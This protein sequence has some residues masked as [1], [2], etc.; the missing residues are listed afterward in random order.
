[1]ILKLAAHVRGDY[2]HK[3]SCCQFIIKILESHSPVCQESLLQPFPVVTGMFLWPLSTFLCFTLIS[4][5]VLITFIKSPNTVLQLSLIDYYNP[6]QDQLEAR[7]SNFTEPRVNSKFFST[8][9]SC[10]S[11]STTVQHWPR[12]DHIPVKNNDVHCP[13]SSLKLSI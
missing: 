13:V 7:Q 2:V 4:L 5:Q 1:M 6:K 8:I 11:S 9:L 3:R 10:S 12:T